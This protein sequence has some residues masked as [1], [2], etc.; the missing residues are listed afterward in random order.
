MA[1][2]TVVAATSATTYQCLKDMNVPFSSSGALSRRHY[3]LVRA[4][5][6]SSSV[7]EANNVLRAEIEAVQV[8]M[9]RAD[10]TLVKSIISTLLAGSHVFS[11][12][13]HGMPHYPSVL[14]QCH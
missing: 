13:M 4:V 7:Q 9:A 1:K 14:L 11:D 10:L 12:S 5:E 8:D 3:G 6:S 2:Q